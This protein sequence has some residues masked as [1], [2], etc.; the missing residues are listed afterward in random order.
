MKVA[1][2]APSPVPFLLGGAENLWWGLVDALN[3]LP[4]VEADLIKLPSAERNASEIV[5]S[6]RRFA[7]LDLSHFDQVISTKYPAWMVAHP[8]HVVYLQH[9]LRGL[10]D[11]YP[12][13]FPTE[14]P[15]GLPPALLAAITRP[16]PERSLLPE[17]FGRIEEWLATHPDDHGFELPG[18]RLRALV[19]QLDRIALAPG[20]IRRYLAISRTVAERADYFPAGVPVEVLHHPT[21][22]HTRPSESFDAIFTASRLDG[23]KRIELLLKAYL[24]AHVDVPLRIAGSGPEQER[25][26]ALAAG[27]PHVQFL[28]RITEAE[29]VDEYAR[30]LFVPF[31]PYQEDYGLITLEAMQ[32]GKAVLTVADAGGVTELVQ[33]GVNGEVVE[34]SEAALAAAIRRLVDDAARTRAMGEAAPATVAHIEWQPLARTLLT[35]PAKR[36][37]VVVANTFPIYPPQGGGQLRLYHLYKGVAEHADVVMVNLAQASETAGVRELAPGFTEIVVPSSH[38][39]STANAL[40]E[41]RLGVPCGDLSAL[42][43]AKLAPNFLDALRRACCDA[44]VVVASHPYAYPALKAVWD[45]P[46]HYESLNA[47]YDLKQAAYPADSP[48]LHAVLEAERECAVAS[49]R[50]FACSG[51]DA[52]RLAELYQLDPA[53]VSVVANG[54]DTCQVRYTDPVERASIRAE[55]GLG[56][57]PL[58]LFM[59]SMHPPNVEALKLLLE[60][61]QACS[62]LDFV[63]LGSVCW[64]VAAEQA[65]ANVR[66][67]G[68]VEEPEKLAWLALADIGFNPMLSGSGTNLKILD[69]AAAGLAIV[70]TPFGARGA[71][72]QPGQHLWQA[73]P[74]G[75]VDLLKTVAALP[76]EQ[77]ARITRAA[78]E[79]VEQTVDW[80]VVSAG[81]AAELLG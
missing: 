22:L 64:G 33:P 43:L 50:V 78:R 57:R 63:V 48:W 7:E 9:K 10:Y 34:T 12:A 35:P 36:K 28:G 11:T 81:Y 4:G 19:L 72:L 18:P 47:E 49:P 65:P 24:A 8:N 39:L 5:A 71:V 14:L 75:L 17:L 52:Q 37:K 60:V 55:Q 38:L 29:L 79:R 74:E 73:E 3:Q 6:Y 40:M 59:G 20:Q 68:V 15:P 31:V 23:A 56:T 42:A 26:Q 67:L 30:A 58:V 13:Q 1:I 51:G 77:Q 44:D 54:T 46:I 41:Q 53:R 25:L 69:Y 70:S 2:V 62:G 27:N 80:R 32:S 66:L 45:G 21:N 76:A 61:A 16:N